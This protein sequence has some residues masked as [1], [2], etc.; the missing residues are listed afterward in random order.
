[1]TGVRKELEGGELWEKEGVVVRKIVIEGDEWKI[2]TIYNRGGVREGLEKVGEM[3]KEEEENMMIIGGDFNARIEKM[4]SIEDWNEGKGRNS[5]DERVNREG[6]WLMEMVADRG[7][8][9]MN[10][11]MERDREENW[12][13]YKGEQKSVIDYGI[14]NA[15]TWG[16]IREMSIGRETDSD[17]MPV[18]IWLNGKG[19]EKGKGEDKLRE[20]Q[21]WDEKGMEEF[22]ERE[23]TIEWKEE[24]VEVWKELLRMI[25]KCVVKRKLK[26]VEGRKEWWDEECGRLKKRMRKMRKEGN[27]E[28][29]MKKAREEY[30]EL[31]KRKKKRWEE[32]MEQKLKSI[33]NE[34][35]AWEFVRGERRDRERITE[36]FEI[37]EWRQNFMGGLGGFKERKVEEVGCE[38]V[39]GEVPELEREEIERSIKGLKKNKAMEVDGVKNEVWKVSEGKITEK[40][41]EVLR[42]VW[43]GEFFPEEWREGIV[44]PIYKKGNREDM[45]NYRRVTLARLIK[46]LQGF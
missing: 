44:V 28:E 45:R 7:W 43:K 11:N 23:K 20:V 30:R 39:S 26:M 27:G 16:E 24:G 25:E 17:H 19:I 15:T 42:R 5:K 1:M 9:V 2:G 21:V 38:G 22:L 6:Q 31:L 35:L 34:R 10:G 13:Y 29:V 4:G 37:E 18:Q 12:T 36:N 3:I 40:L 14:T 33:D 41:E 8:M 32:K 46:F